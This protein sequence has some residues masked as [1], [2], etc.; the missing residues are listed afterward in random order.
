M[1]AGLGGDRP[2]ICWTSTLSH[3]LNVCERFAVAF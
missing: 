1:L 2:G 3:L